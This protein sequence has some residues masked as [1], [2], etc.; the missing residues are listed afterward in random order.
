MPEEAVEQ[1]WARQEAA[2]VEARLS[3]GQEAA[4]AQ[5]WEQRPVEEV[6]VAVQPSA[7]QVVEVGQLWAAPAAAEV[8]LWG[9][10]A[11]AEAARPLAR[12]LAA[13]PSAV[14]SAC[15]RDRA[16]QAQLARQQSRARWTP[17]PHS[18]RHTRP[19]ARWW[20]GERDEALS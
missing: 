5:P 1:L 7:E 20:R 13:A 18:V 19:K 10:R 12:R 9:V 3:E 2:A 8:R 4:A 6:G 14:A 16:R 15:R 11:V 17:V